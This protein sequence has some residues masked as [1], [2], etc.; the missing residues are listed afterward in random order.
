MWKALTPPTHTYKWRL[1][2]N[3]ALGFRARALDF[4]EN[5]GERKER[6]ECQN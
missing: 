6:T 4:I 2:P 5:A 1:S 3:K